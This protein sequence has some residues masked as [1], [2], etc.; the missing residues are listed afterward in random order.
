VGKQMTKKL[1]N[2]GFQVVADL[3][4]VTNPDTVT[5][6]GTSSESLRKIWEQTQ[7]SLDD[8]APNPVDHRLA[9]NPYKSKFGD[10]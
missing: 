2:A 7:Q 5:I 4:S 9:P 6:E 8:D 1:N 10:E 3:K